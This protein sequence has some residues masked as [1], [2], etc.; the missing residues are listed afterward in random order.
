MSIEELRH[1]QNKL[2]RQPRQRCATDSLRTHFH[3]A[4]GRESTPVGYFSIVCPASNSGGIRIKGR[5]V[6]GVIAVVEPRL[7]A[8]GVLATRQT[9]HSLGPPPFSIARS[10]SLTLTRI[11]FAHSLALLSPHIVIM[12][13]SCCSRSAPKTPLGMICTS[14][15]VRW[16]VLKKAWIVA[17]SAPLPNRRS[18]Y[19]LVI[20]LCITDCGTRAPT[21]SRAAS[22]RT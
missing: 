21:R 20:K 3:V 18:F 16:A 7:V 19:T 13:A 1:L 8:P 17:R 14:L 5:K 4:S 10:R 11:S 22:H 9:T 2:C 12:V 15:A 6:G